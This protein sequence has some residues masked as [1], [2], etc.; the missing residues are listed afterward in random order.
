LHLCRS[1][2]K[3]SFGYAFSADR[4]NCFA[5]HTLIPAPFMQLAG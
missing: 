2:S 5:H 3:H 1:P 4:P